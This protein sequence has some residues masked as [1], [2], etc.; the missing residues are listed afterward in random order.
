[1]WLSALLSSVL[2]ITLFVGV[3]GAILYNALSQKVSA[4]TLDISHLQVGP[5]S[6]PE[7]DPEDVVPSDSFEGRPVNVLLMGIDARMDQDESV[8]DPDG[9]NLDPTTR[10]DTTLMLHIA[11]DRESV[12]LI[13][14]P[15]DMWVLLP[16]CRRTDGSISSEQWGQFNWAFAYGAQ[17]DDI[18][19][20]VA[21][22]QATVQSLTGITPDGF[23]VIDFTGFSRMVEALGGVNVCIDEAIDETRYVGLTLEAGCQT[24]NPVEATQ[25][26]RV[27]YV[28]DGSDMGR[29]QRQQGLLGSMAMDALDSNLLTDLPSL[30]AF[31]AT[32]IESTK[33]SPSLSSLR[34]DAGLA[35]SLRGIDPENIRFVTMPVLTADFDYNRLLPMEPRNTELWEAIMNDEPLP[36]GTVFMDIN[37][38]YFTFE[39]NGQIVPGGDPRT[40]NEIG[41]F[42]GWTPSR[43][44]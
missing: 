29:I 18:A 37:G 7:D 28:G 24:L 14:I 30:Y 40:D 8:V 35:S 10:S 25:Y 13:S 42:T 33:V 11:E 26:A 20:G 21:C 36:E 15:R 32:S 22:T 17:T 39:E 1:M 31:I 38:D 5:Q 12:Y 23:A 6:V 44:S 3:A 16:E 43:D 4:Q 27:R 9:G 19:A 34:G 41:Y 2:A